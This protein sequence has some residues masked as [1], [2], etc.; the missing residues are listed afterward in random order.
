MHRFLHLVNLCESAK[1]AARSEVPEARL[2]TTS[3]LAQNLAGNPACYGHYC[4]GLRHMHLLAV[5]VA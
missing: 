3:D 5:T 2:G 1:L 4:T